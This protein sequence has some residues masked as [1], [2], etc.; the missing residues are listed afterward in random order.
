MEGEGANECVMIVGGDFPHDGAKD[1]DDFVVFAVGHS[2]DPD[3]E[4]GGAWRITGE[5][6]LPPPACIPKRQLSRTVCSSIVSSG[7]R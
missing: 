4:V 5:E 7:P 1:L 2:D 3:T 6:L